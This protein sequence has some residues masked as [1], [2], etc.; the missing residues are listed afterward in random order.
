MVRLLSKIPPYIWTLFIILLVGILIYKSPIGIDLADK[1]KISAGLVSV[2]GLFF[3][4]IQMQL[5]KRNN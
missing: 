5:Q 1:V 4:A 2:I 3:V